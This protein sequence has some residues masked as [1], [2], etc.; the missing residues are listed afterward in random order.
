MKK[1][2]NIII[3]FGKAGKTL[4][5]D[6]NARE[7]E[8]VLIEKDPKMYGGTCINVACIPSK[9]LALLAQ[10][11]PQGVNEKAYYKDSI[12]EK[13]E[14]VAALNK[15]N[16]KKVQEN[17][18]VE[19][20]DGFASFIEDKQVRVALNDGGEETYE[21]DR[22]FINTGSRPNVP[23][24]EGLEI[25]AERIHTS[26]TLMEDEELPNSL[27]ILGDGKISLEFAS[28]YAQFGSK[29]TVLSHD[30]KEN[31]LEEEDR[32]IAEAVLEAL[33]NLGIE[34]IF[35]AETTRVQN[36]EEGLFVSYEKNHTIHSIQADKLLVAVGR[37]ANISKLNLEAAGVYIAENESIQVNK[38]LETNVS[39]IF[40]LGDVNGGPQH[41]YLSLDDYR[42]VRSELFGDGSYSLAERENIPATTFTYPPLSTVGLSER[43][44]IEEGYKVR[45]ATLPVSEIPKAKMVNHTTG[46]YKAVVDADTDQILGAALFAEDSHEVINVLATAIKGA[47]TYQDLANQVFTHPSM[48]EA[49]N[50]LFGK[51]E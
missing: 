19:V 12:Q 11:K 18:F 4:A 28:I 7:E 3:G 13:K 9:K 20:I 17:E 42:I 24:I 35:E 29:V 15:A 45:V 39:N 8:T 21:A 33:Q 50:D 5:Q 26:E 36:R 47:F 49:L 46:L 14:L 34:F 43:R 30:A 27:T 25:D 37:H 38:H 16:Y 1:V 48:A 31:F 51:F 2:K 22:I 44:A 23:S 40:A 10:E 41:T 32:D 6:L